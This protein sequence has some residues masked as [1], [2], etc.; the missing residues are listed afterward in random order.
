VIEHRQTR[1]CRTILNCTRTCPKN[2]NPAEAMKLIVLR[3]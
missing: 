2:L 3:R 1:R